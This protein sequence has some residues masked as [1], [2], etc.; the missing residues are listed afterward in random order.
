[1]IDVFPS[2]SCLAPL[3]VFILAGGLGTRIRPALGEIPKPLAPIAGRPSL[4]HLHDV[5][6]QLPPGSLAAFSECSSFVD[7]GTP[8][9]LSLARTML[10]PAPASDN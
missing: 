7:I 10:G 6:E 9:S 5:F 3:D 8:D 1:L 2:G 4:D